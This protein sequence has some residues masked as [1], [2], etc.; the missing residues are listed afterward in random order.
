MLALILSIVG[1]GTTCFPL[2]FAAVYFGV[3]ARKQARDIGD[4]NNSNA[5]LGLVGIIVGAI[6]GSLWGLYW[7]FNGM[8]ILAYVGLVFAAIFAAAVG[9]P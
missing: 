3:K 1:I 7:L 6:F 8:I 5:T 4:P 9:G 2:G